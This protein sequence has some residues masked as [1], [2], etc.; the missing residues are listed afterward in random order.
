MS[1]GKPQPK[2]ELGHW[3]SH[4]H[5]SPLAFK[6]A[7]TIFHLVDVLQAFDVIPPRHLHP[8]VQAYPQDACACMLAWA[9][10]ACALVGKSH[11]RGIRE[12]K[13]YVWKV[14]LELVRNGRPTIAAIAQAVQQDTRRSMRRGWPR[15]DGRRVGQRARRGCNAAKWAAAC[16]RQGDRRPARR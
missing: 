4:R 14:R 9:V 10:L 11:H 2:H 7:V 16:R 13:L 12:D 6:K 3:L 1:T 15:H 5:S 8:P